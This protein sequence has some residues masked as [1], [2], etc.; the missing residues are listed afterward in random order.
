M[1]SSKQKGC[2]DKQTKST[3]KHSAPRPHKH[4]H[5]SIL[6]GHKIVCESM[7]FMNCHGVFTR[8]MSLD[9]WNKRTLC[10]DIK[11]LGLQRLKLWYT[12]THATHYS[13][14]VLKILYATVHMLAVATCSYP[15]PSHTEV[16]KDTS[17]C[18]ACDQ[19]FPAFPNH[20]Q[21][22][23]VWPPYIEPTRPFQNIL[24]L[25]EVCSCSGS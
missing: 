20:V 7:I 19:W 24:M 5:S 14:N 23:I 1:R 3:D 12:F 13:T 22:E 21:W 17:Q 9:C 4:T 15:M 6:W 18:P 8:A 25:E 2:T 10:F 16:W 11:S